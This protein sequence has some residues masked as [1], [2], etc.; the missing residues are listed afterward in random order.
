MSRLLRALGILL[1]IYLVIRFAFGTHIEWSDYSVLILLAVG[2]YIVYLVV[3]QSRKNSVPASGKTWFYR[4]IGLAVLIYFFR[5]V[6]LLMSGGFFLLLDKLLQVSDNIPPFIM[7]AIVGSSIGLIVGSFI[8]R[9]KYNLSFKINLIPIAIFVLLIFILAMIN[10][11]LARKPTDDEIPAVQQNA[12]RDIS[13]LS[14]KF[15]VNRWAVVD[16]RGKSREN[17]QRKKNLKSLLEFKKNG[18]CY[19]TEDGVRKLVVYYTL[20]P[21]GRFISFTN[22]NNSAESRQMQIISITKD[23]LVVRSEL[24]QNDTAIL[25]SR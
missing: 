4:M 6:F 10:E 21:D 5:S 15:I 1:V 25:K 7:W 14:K 17:F 22:P 24:F 13:E 12:Y 16:V 2:V 3:K 20:S 9:K 23:E 18:K 19:L 11:P 8:V